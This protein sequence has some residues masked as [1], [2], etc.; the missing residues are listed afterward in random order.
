MIGILDSGLGGLTFARRIHREMPEAGFIYLGD[1]ARFPYGDKSD[2]LIRQFA[3]ENLERL[4]KTGVNFVVVV[5]HTTWCVAGEILGKH[6]PLPLYNPVEPAVDAALGLSRYGRI[7]IVGTLA[8]VRSNG[9]TRMLTRRSPGIEV[10]ENNTPLLVPLV[11]AGWQKKP[12]TG[13]ILRKGLIPLKSRQIDTLIPA[14]NHYATLQDRIVAKAG[15]R[16]RVVDTGGALAA[17]VRKDYDVR[18][19]TEKKEGGR[20]F[21]VTDITPRTAAVAKAL[22]QFNL[23]LEKA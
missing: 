21:F 19:S 15:K 22:Y 1:T 14:C 5:C 20:R 12:E 2:A 6:C 16:I 18:R 10:V 23:T 4:L 9:Y 3:V 7:G 11:E 8:M 13:S 17:L